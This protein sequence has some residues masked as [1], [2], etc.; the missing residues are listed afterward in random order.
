MSRAL[1]WLSKSPF[2]RRIEKVVLPW[3]FQQPT[4]TIYNGRTDPVEHV[5]Q[6]NQRMA[7]HFRNEALMCK[8]FPSSLGLVAMRWFNSLKAN[9]I[10]SYRQLAQAFGSRFVTN[11]KP[12]RPMS[13]LLSLSMS[14][15]ETLKA[16]SDKYWEIYNELDGKFD[17][18]AI[19]T[20]KNRLPIGHGLRKSLTSK[21]ATSVRQLMDRIDKYKR[22]EEDLLQGRGKEKVIPRERRDSRSDRYN[23]A[24]PRKDSVGQFGVTN[25]QIVSAVFREPVHK[26]LER[27]RNEPYFRWPNKMAG[28]PEKRDQS[29]YCQYHQDHG[30]ATEDCRNLWNYLDR[31]VQEGKLKHLLHHSSGHQGQT[32]QE[33]R[34][35]TAMGQLAGTINVILAAP[36]RTGTCPS[37]VLSVIQVTAEESQSGPKR[38]RGG[39]HP[40]LSFSEED[41][42]GTT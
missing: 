22:V 26:V 5:S 30:H 1:D 38:A 17:N 3:W 6:F 35:D 14:D 27:I 4:F 2:T 28:D 24:Y 31:L 12:P 19:N 10:G 32:Y 20:F 7:V 23:N 18:V 13:A 36:G 39:S 29:R 37:Q 34:R 41:K 8:V 16:Y 40:T 9:S 11:S 25:A 33:P 15:G 42:D 21:P